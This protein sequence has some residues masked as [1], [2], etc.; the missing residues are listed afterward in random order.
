M[1]YLRLDE[2]RSAATHIQAV[3]RGYQIRCL[4]FAP[5]YD[6]YVAYSQ[7]LLVD[8]DTDY[9]LSESVDGFYWIHI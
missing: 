7:F 5:D 6:Q 3:F 9:L 4:R 8:C 2:T 1:L